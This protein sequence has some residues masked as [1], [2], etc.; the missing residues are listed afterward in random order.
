MKRVY[1]KEKRC[2]EAPARVAACPGKAV[3]YGRA[4]RPAAVR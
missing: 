1:V 4:I 3:G 2:Q